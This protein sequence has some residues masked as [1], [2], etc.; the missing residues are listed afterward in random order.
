MTE[1]FADCKRIALLLL[2]F[3]ISACGA[4]SGGGEAPPVQPAAAS[5]EDQGTGEGRA[6]KAE[7]A[8]PAPAVPLL[9]EPAP[10]EVRQVADGSI[11]A[12]NR[13]IA[14]RRP[15]SDSSP[16][17]GFQELDLRRWSIEA[18]IFSPAV[19]CPPGPAACSPMAEQLSIDVVS[20][21]EDTGVAVVIIAPAVGAAAAAVLARCGPIPPLNGPR[22][23]CRSCPSCDPTNRS[24]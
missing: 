3:L 24:S 13:V 21:Q 22:L 11:S 18:G 16:A 2:T 20:L 7:P 9:P 4:G 10:R 6:L 14:Q 1:R 15:R 5:A 19:V 23:T 8:L 12:S 17:D